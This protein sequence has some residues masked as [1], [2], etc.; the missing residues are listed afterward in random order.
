[1]IKVLDMMSIK[2]AKHKNVHR[3]IEDNLDNPFHL[4]HAVI[5]CDKSK[6]YLSH[7]C[8][9]QD[10]WIV[11][12]DL[13]MLNFWIDS[14]TGIDGSSSN[15]CCNCSVLLRAVLDCSL[16]ISSR[17][18]SVLLNF[19]FVFKIGFIKSSCEFFIF[20]FFHYIALL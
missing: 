10:S 1:M 19:F 18:D 3:W 13:L 20:F 16:P 14:L 4:G 12:L 5:E 11:V 2:I 8:W 15:Y 7:Q 6:K 17:A 9:L